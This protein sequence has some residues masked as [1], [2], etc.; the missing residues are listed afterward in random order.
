MSNRLGRRMMK[1]IERLKRSS[2]QG[3]LKFVCMS[4][5]A[6]LAGAR[7]HGA[8]ALL[9]EEPYG[10]FGA[11]NPTGHAAVYL[12]HVCAA[13][14]TELRQCHEGEFGVVI[15]RYHKI[16][17]LDW[18]AMPLL[19]YLYAANDVSQIPMTVDKAKVA[20]QRDAY[21]REYLERLAPDDKK[22]HTPKGEWTQLVGASYDRTIHG[23]EV[24][25]T[26]E[27]DE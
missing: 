1:I 24:V 20:E 7:A 22:G 16:D 4:V 18:I 23:F 17:K 3:A 27:E 19:A 2:R 5:I 14:P 9:M 26:P 11:M 10:D 13:S 25:S 15:S 21:R 6:T 8:V 12:N